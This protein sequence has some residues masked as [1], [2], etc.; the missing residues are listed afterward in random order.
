MMKNRIIIIM[1]ASVLI[2][3]LGA[4]AAIEDGDTMA[5]TETVV[6][7]T[8]EIDDTM[9]ASQGEEVVTVMN[10]DSML[11][12]T[13]IFTDRDLEQ[14]A[15]ISDA[16]YFTVISDEV[17]TIEGAG[18]Y[19]ISGVATNATIIVDAGD[20]DKVQL[21]LDKVSLINESAPAIYVKSVDKVFVTTTDSNNLLKVTD[22]FEGDGDTNLDAVI[23]S[24]SDLVLNGLGVLTIES[25]EG[26]GVTSKDDLKVTGGS[27]YITSA[28]DAMEAKDSIRIYDGF[29]TIVTDKDGLHSENEDDGSLGYIYVLNGSLDIDAGDDAIHA[30]SIFQIDGGTI[31][32]N[33]SSEGIEGNYVQINGGVIDIYATDDGI[34]ATSLSDIDVV[35]E[36]NDGV[37]TIDMGSGDTDGFDANGDIVINGGTISVSGGSTFDADESATLNGGTVYVNGVEVT[38]L[39]SQQ[40]DRQKK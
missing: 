8:V 16:Q 30:N 2:L 6:E 36:V 9:S 35:I 10:D 37:I 38:E 26:N 27:Y 17:I 24:K 13:D 21:V 12:L 29:I 5:V 34:N 40:N 20:E 3:S 1:I 32:I 18:V 15:D 22:S 14:V 19:V 31:L 33:S 11:D 39:P 4:C 23:F 7:S 25:Q 28:K